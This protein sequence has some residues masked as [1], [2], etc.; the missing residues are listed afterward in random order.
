MN[1]VPGGRFR[2][3][4]GALVRVLAVGDQFR[5]LALPDRGE[6]LLR[7]DPRPVSLTDGR[8]GSP[9]DRREEIRA[10]QA[11][12]EAPPFGF[13]FREKPFGRRRHGLELDDRLVAGFA[14]FQAAGDR[15]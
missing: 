2:D 8:E 10:V 13:R 6:R 3:E 5:E 4:T 9:V 7:D 14:G 12:A 11:R 15:P 1:Q